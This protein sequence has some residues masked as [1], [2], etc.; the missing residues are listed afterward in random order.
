MHNVRPDRGQ[1]ACFF[2]PGLGN[3]YL[4]RTHQHGQGV[5]EFSPP[6]QWATISASIWIF[7]K[8]QEFKNRQ[9]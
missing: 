9:F 6:K 8:T 5:L 4:R 1:T 7:F 2:F 3:A